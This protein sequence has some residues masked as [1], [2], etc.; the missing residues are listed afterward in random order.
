MVK[1]RLS[2]VGRKKDP[3][4]RIIAIDES[5]KNIGKALELLGYWNP[6]K[7]DIEVKKEQ[8]K[9]WVAKGAI[10]SDAVKKLMEK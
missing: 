7:N 9:A 3:F 1:V 2:K 5:K 6:R 4:F 8:I 10:V